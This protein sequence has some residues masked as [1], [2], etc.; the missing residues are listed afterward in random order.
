VHDQDLPAALAAD[1]DGNFEHLV[2][3]FQ[4]RLYAFALRLTGSPQDAEE[5]TQDAFVRAYR[6]LIKYPAARLQTLNL[7]PWLYQITL[8]VCR[9]RA[10]QRQPQ[11]VALDRGNDEGDWDLT[12]D[13]EL[14][15][16]TALEQAEVK[17]ALDAL[18]AGLPKRYRLAVVLRH[19]QGLGYREMAVVLKQPVGTIKANV[20][21]GVRMLRQALDERER[22][23]HPRPQL[24]AQRGWK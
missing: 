7:R 3:A 13:N 22:T 21:R 10:R 5:I 17:T 12:D 14:R 11:L 15:P 6:A 1:V 4:D 18:V 8:N 9:N 20:H 19:I 2:L 23:G 16:D 24:R